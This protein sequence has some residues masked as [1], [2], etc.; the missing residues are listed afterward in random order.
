MKNKRKNEIMEDVEDYLDELSEDAGVTIDK[1]QLVSL[2][3]EI[4]ISN[5]RMVTNIA[6][7][8]REKHNITESGF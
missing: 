2:L 5:W 4:K 8:I 6:N 7:E 1:E 3:Y